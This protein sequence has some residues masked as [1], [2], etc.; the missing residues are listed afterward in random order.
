M[1][2][3]LPI[4]AS[5]FAAC[6]LA[7]I[8]PAQERVLKAIV[9]EPIVVNITALAPGR[10]VEVEDAKT[11]KKAE[12]TV[13]RKMQWTVGKKKLTTIKVVKLEL[14]RLAADPASMRPNPATG[15]KQIAWVRVIPGPKVQWAE[16]LQVWDA[17]NAAGFQRCVIDGIGTNDIMP[18]AI[19]KPVVGKVGLTL[20]RCDFCDPD[21]RV[22]KLRPVID[23][24]RDGRVMSGGRRVFELQ[25]VPPQNLEPL[26][27]ELRML[28]AKMEKAGKLDAR[29]GFDGKWVEMPILVRVDH[30]TAWRDVLR[31]LR[32][33]TKPD[34]GFWKLELAVSR[35]STRLR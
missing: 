17:V 35:R 24:H 23:V 10:V 33:L 8:A 34:V 2:R 26:R 25:A 22:P 28:H 15:G 18:K 9:G 6:L 20:A 7:A 21:V 27:V 32:E 11:K 14:E 29:L 4:L 1:M 16:V 19:A 12:R 5:T 13:D 3:T 31:L 30:K